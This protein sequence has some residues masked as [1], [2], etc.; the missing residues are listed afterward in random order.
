MENIVNKTDGWILPEEIKP[1]EVTPRFVTKRWVAPE[2]LN[3]EG[4]NQEQTAAN[5]LSRLAER[6]SKTKLEEYLKMGTPLAQVCKIEHI[7]HGTMGK[8]LKFHNVDYSRHPRKS[9]NF[10]GEVYGRLKIVAERK[11]PIARGWQRIAICQCECGN[12]KETDYRNLSKG[13]TKSCGCLMDERSQIA[14]A[15]QQERQLKKENRPIKIPKV[16]IIREP[17]AA[18]PKR[19]VVPRPVFAELPKEKLESYLAGDLRLKE[20]C[21]IEKLP[22][23]RFFGM[24]RRNGLKWKR[25]R[26]RR[27]PKADILGER[28]GKLVATAIHPS[29]G[30]YIEYLC[31]CDCGKIKISLSRDLRSGHNKSC[32]C[33][34]GKSENASAYWRK[35]WQD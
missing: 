21:E 19:V 17:K 33:L 31:Q 1:V 13:R 3:R 16:K 11:V 20:I 12:Q 29:T 22:E 24:L 35:I 15:H 27:K 30:K 25:K 2:R 14:L 28:F 32:G 23:D 7:G 6:L 8:L 34:Q 18:Q 4:E 9:R 26:E 10:I 5:F